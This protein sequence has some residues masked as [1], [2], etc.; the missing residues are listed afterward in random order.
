MILELSFSQEY[1]ANFMPIHLVIFQQKTFV[2]H[3]H[4]GLYLG[5]IITSRRFNIRCKS[6]LTYNLVK[7]TLKPSQQDLIEDLSNARQLRRS[8]LSYNAKV[9]V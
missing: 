1:I 2:L 6:I 9:F 7:L 5:K 3:G 8:S 4:L